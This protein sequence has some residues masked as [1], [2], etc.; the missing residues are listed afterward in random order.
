MKPVIVSWRIARCSYL[1]G[2][3]MNESSSV[4]ARMKSWLRWFVLTAATYVSELKR[5]ASTG[6][7]EAS[8]PQSP[9]AKAAAKSQRRRPERLPCFGGPCDGETVVDEGERQIVLTHFVTD[10]EGAVIRAT[11]CVYDY[12]GDGF[13]FAGRQQMI[14]I[15]E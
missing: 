1:D 7:C 4:T 8:L 12:C 14:R 9:E 11:N 2:D 6:S 5:L 3:K 10:D 13:E 15:A